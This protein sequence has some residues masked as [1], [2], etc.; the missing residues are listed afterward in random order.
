MAFFESVRLA[1]SRHPVGVHDLASGASPSTL[2]ALLV[3]LPALRSAEFFDFLSTWNGG[4]MFHE[5]LCLRSAEDVAQV[6]TGQFLIGESSDGT[7]WLDEQGRVLVVDAEE[8]DPLSA[9]SDFATWLDVVMAREA[10]LLDRDGEFR[11]V[12]EEEDGVLQPEIRRKRAQL[13]RKRDAQATLYPVELAELALEAGDDDK[14]RSLLGDA[15]SLSG[16]LGPAW[17]LL[18][19][20][21]RQAGDKEAAHASYLRAA[22]ASVSGSLRAM[23]LLEA[24]ELAPSAAASLVAAATDSDP[25]LADRL[26]SQVRERLLSHEVDEAKQLLAKLHLLIGRLPVGSSTELERIERDLRARDALRVI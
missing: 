9:G 7:L 3:R 20:L 26:L 8:P 4:S 15:V 23:R 6:S 1:L 12:F 21:E 24:A 5:S 25:G 18:G 19:A 11:D 2:N 17:E 14:A 22:Q 16:P 10:L 13:G